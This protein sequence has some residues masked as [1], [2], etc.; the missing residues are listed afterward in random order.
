MR[1]NSTNELGLLPA[2]IVIIVV[3]VVGV[4][5]VCGSFVGNFLALLTRH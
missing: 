4:V 5:V 3:V 2:V 1:K